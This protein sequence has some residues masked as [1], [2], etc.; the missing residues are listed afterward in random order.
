MPVKS[1]NFIAKDLS[2]ALALR[3][4]VPKSGIDSD[5]RSVAKKHLEEWSKSE[6]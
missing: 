2:F 6:I 4:I 5:I 1:E 3:L